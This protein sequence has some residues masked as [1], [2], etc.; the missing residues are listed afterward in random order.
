M[1]NRKP[2]YRPPKS[3]TAEAT[4]ARQ[5][6]SKR[7]KRVKERAQN[8]SGI[9][10]A[11]LLC[12]YVTYIYLIDGI[13]LSEY[14]DPSDSEFWFGTIPVFIVFF[15]IVKIVERIARKYFGGI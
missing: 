6:E 11:I 14:L 7:E 4:R 15:I 1:S 3:I 10:G 9:V 8:V 2:R 12:L 5:E 13:R